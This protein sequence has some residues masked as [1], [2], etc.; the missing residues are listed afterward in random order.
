MNNN[1]SPAL[2]LHQTVICFNMVPGGAACI[3]DTAMLN[4]SM[5]IISE[6]TALLHG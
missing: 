4:V 5:C 2:P 1:C 3:P 6:G